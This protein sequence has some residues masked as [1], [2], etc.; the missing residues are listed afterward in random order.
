MAGGLFLLCLLSALPSACER[1]ASGTESDVGAKGDPVLA[2]T[3]T[4]PEELAREVLGAIER[5]DV[6]TLK[7]LPL[8][9]DEFR[10]YVW[11]KLPS[12]RPERNVPMEYV[13]KTLQQ[14]SVGS[15]ARNFGRYKGR[16]LELLE[17]EFEGETTDYG[18]FQVHRDAR[19]RVRD[20][21]TN[22]EGWLDLFGSVMERQGKYKLFS[23][24][25][26]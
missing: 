16:K 10:L 13:W 2:R 5:E 24:V 7:A 25:T 12:S 3:F 21:E 15:I 26:D 19:L 6:E 18:T 1:N 22:E 9:K 4:S 23:Y 11:P 17:I 8:S 20:R 14:K